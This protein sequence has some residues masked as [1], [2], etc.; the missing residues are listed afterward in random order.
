MNI[1]D[2]EQE[3]RRQPLRQ[4]PG[5]WRKEILTTAESAA[6]TRRAPPAIRPSW[7]STFNSQ[8]SILL[9]PHPKAWAGLA[10]IWLLILAADFSMRDQ[11][12]GVAEKSA[13][14][15][16][17]VMVELRQQQRMLV[18]LIGSR[19]EHA[20]VRSKSYVPQPRSDWRFEILRA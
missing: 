16:P 4:V 14:P 7:L 1:D 13:P 15:S 19:D 9:W 2:F 8:L 20:A 18:E 5:E 6:V 10:A 11:S 12:P 17:E 3:L